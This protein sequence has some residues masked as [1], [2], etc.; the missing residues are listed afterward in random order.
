[1]DE[2]QVAWEMFNE[3][4]ANSDGVLGVSEAIAYLVTNKRRDASA[5][6]GNTTWWQKMD[7]DHS[8]Y[9]EPKEFDYSLA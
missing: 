7:K 3:I 2:V 4:D 1:M 5:L 8:G 6:M 9:L